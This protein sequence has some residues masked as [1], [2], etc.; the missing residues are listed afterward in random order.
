MFVIVIDELKHRLKVRGGLIGVS[1]NNALNK[2]IEDHDLGMDVHNFATLPTANLMRSKKMEHDLKWFE[3]Y[4]NHHGIL[5]PLTDE[6]W[7]ELGTLL[8][9]INSVNRK[10]QIDASVPLLKPKYL[11]E[12]YDPLTVMKDIPDMPDYETVEPSLHITGFKKIPVRRRWHRWNIKEP[13]GYR[14]DCSC[15]WKS[16]VMPDCVSAR[17]EAELHK[18]RK[19]EW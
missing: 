8:H 9:Q 7:N 11:T 13:A 10:T 6:E 15:G 3:E 14:A 5:E 4:A 19:E 2:I 18:I 17:Q 12:G 16:S 1:L